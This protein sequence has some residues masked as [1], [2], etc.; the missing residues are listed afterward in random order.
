MPEQVATLVHLN[1][2]QEKHGEESVKAADLKVQFTTNCAWLDEL[3]PGLAAAY[4]RAE[5]QKAS[6]AE[7]LFEPTQPL[8]LTVRRWP[9][10]AGFKFDHELTAMRVTVN[11][12]IRDDGAIVLDGATVDKFAVELLEGGSIVVTYRVKCHPSADDMAKLYELLDGEIDIAAEL[13]SEYRPAQG[14]LVPEGEKTT[15]PAGA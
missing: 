6:T 5:E 10:I 12:G 8:P 14:S 3:E 13:G 7:Q 15:E 11:F 1:I 9:K 4:Y 2:R